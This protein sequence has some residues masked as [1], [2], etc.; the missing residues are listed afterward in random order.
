[1]VFPGFIPNKFN[2]ITT[3]SHQLL[4]IPKVTTILW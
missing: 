1:M 4:D 2:K 3:I